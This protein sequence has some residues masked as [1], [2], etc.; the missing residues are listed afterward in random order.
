[1]RTQPSL[2]TIM[3]MEVCDW[4]MNSL[5]FSADVRR[6]ASSF[7]ASASAV[8]DRRCEAALDCSV[9][10]WAWGMELG[11]NVGHRKHIDRMTHEL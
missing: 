6:V 3:S 10:H 7:F 4:G 2:T 9:E 8:C 1:M 11:G 5:G